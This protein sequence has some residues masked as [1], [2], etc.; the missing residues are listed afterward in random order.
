MP[1]IT[2]KGE[3]HTLSDWARKLKVSRATLQSRLADGWTF[4]QTLEGKR[5]S[6]KGRKGKWDSA[7]NKKLTSDMITDNS[8]LLISE[9]FM[10]EIRKDLWQRI[11]RGYQT[12]DIKA[13]FDTQ[14]CGLMLECLGLDCTGEEAYEKMVESIKEDMAKRG[15]ECSK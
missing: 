11:K 12:H 1:I 10:R 14:L 4:E 3:T 2:Y 15:T 13:V 7:A 6:R 8:V 9:A 5:P